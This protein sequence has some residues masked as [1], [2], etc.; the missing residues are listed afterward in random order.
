[1]TIPTR[2]VER[3][4]LNPDLTGAA[5]QVAF[6]LSSVLTDPVDDET[7]ERT[8]TVA[9]LDDTGTFSV[10]LPCTSGGDIQEAGVT[11]AVTEYIAGSR[12][13]RYFITL[14]DTL[15]DP[16]NL[17]DLAPASSSTGTTWT[18]EFME[19]GSLVINVTDYGATGNGSTDDA[20][21]IQAAIV[22]VEALASSN[23]AGATLYFPP[24][25]YKL[26]SGNALALTRNNDSTRGWV[27]IVFA[28]GASLVLSSSCPRAFDFRRVADYDW[29]RKVRLVDVTI[30]A[31]SINGNGDA[32][33]GSWQNSVHLQRVN[34]EDIE[35][36]RPHIYNLPATLPT[37]LRAHIWLDSNE[38]SPYPGPTTC[39]MRRITIERPRLYG[40]DMGIGIAGTPAGASSGT[41]TN[42]FVDDILVTDPIIELNGSAPAT[43]L[44]QSG[45]N[46][47]GSGTCGTVRV[48]RPKVKWSGDVGVE[49]NACQDAIIDTPLTI[50][51]KIGVYVQNYH[52]LTDAAQST[53]K[54]LNPRHEVTSAWVAA[55][56]NGIKVGSVNP[57]G[58][59]IVRN[60]E[61]YC[62]TQVFSTWASWVGMATSVLASVREFDIDGFKARL[63]NGSADSA[64]TMT[65]SLLDVGTTY[66]GAIIKAKNLDGYVAYDRG[67]SG[68]ANLR[69][70]S[71]HATSATLMLGPGVAWETAIT[72]ATN[73]TQHGVAIG[74]TTSGISTSI[75][76][77][78][79]VGLAPRSMS[80]DSNPRGIRFFAGATAGSVIGGSGFP[81]MF[82][83]FSALSG[84]QADND[85]LWADT[86]TKVKLKLAGNVYR[87]T[88]SRPFEGTKTWDP[89]SVAD[90]AQT[91]TTVTVTGAALG[92]TVTCAFSQAVPAGCILS[93][94]VTATDTVTVTLVNHSGGAVD[95]ASG[96]L[97]VQ[98]IASLV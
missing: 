65:I 29:F 19:V 66:S 43:T 24:G 9:P 74:E 7:V 18:T 20:T 67:G 93:A 12:P 71:F 90:G 53:V 45:I 60:Q 88:T 17:A 25:R 94:Q 83:D 49:V 69:V 33:I 96:T 10:E 97:R 26:S 22:A 85:V 63:T 37:K 44:T 56:S 92:D 23:T 57:H 36:I 30:D 41:G 2:T 48:I 55:Y 52:P 32:V 79:A 4:Y 81:V 58:R 95:L 76:R 98:R 27:N 5:G 68:T 16:V 84:G 64:S 21:S 70:F 8:T 13:N 50:D 34:F 73:F 87:S 40:G 14:P 46:I 77:G 31:N 89:A 54:I 75:F 61:W 62:D 47:G 11:Y 15:P 42:L 72:S 80:G 59:I 39:Y 6:R 35:I 91:S 3:T 82:C 78:Y 86:E 51:C 1:M 38:P 28:K